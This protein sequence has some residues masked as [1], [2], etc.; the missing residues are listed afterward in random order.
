MLFFLRATGE[1][2]STPPPPTINRFTKDPDTLNGTT[3]QFQYCDGQGRVSSKTCKRWFVISF[4][5][6]IKNGFIKKLF[7]KKNIKW[8]HEKY[9][10]NGKF[11]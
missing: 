11:H 3:K 2:F 9:F 5:H 10:C 7:L 4:A 8:F 6:Y 1:G